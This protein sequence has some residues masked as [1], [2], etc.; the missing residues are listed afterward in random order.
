M[1]SHESLE[2]V[3]SRSQSSK[4][5]TKTVLSSRNWS[6]CEIRLARSCCGLIIICIH[7]FVVNYFLTPA[8]Q[9]NESILPGKVLLLVAKVSKRNLR[10]FSAYC[11]VVYE[12]V[13]EIERVR[14]GNKTAIVGMAPCSLKIR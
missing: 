11:V 10:Q 9:R 6:H 2:I 14:V 3:E 4:D 5:C 13:Q 8:I 12:Q 7:I 1:H